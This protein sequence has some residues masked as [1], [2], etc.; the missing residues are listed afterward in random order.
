ML[1]S[2]PKPRFQCMTLLPQNVPL[3]T[4]IKKNLLLFK[5]LFLSPVYIMYLLFLLI[6]GWLKMFLM[7][8]NVSTGI[9]C[10]I[11]IKWVGEGKKCFLMF[12]EI[13]SVS[14]LIW[15]FP[16]E[17]SYISGI[18]E[19]ATQLKISWF[20]FTVSFHLFIGAAKP[21]ANFRSEP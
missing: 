17:P 3:V 19:T 14:M 1:Q 5:E 20:V 4:S 9:I 6:S 13:V 7:H 16:Q 10:W 2:T 8:W 15:K 12:S 11:V 21:I 18:S